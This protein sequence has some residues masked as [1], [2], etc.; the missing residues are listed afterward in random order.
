M[1]QIILLVSLVFVFLSCGG[2]KVSTD[3]D[4]STNF[5]K[6]QTYTFYKNMHTGLDEL[7][8]KRLLNSIRNELNAKG[9]TESTSK[10][11]FHVNVKT[12]KRNKPSRTHVRL[13]IGGGSHHV[14]GNVSVGIPVGQDKLDVK[15]EYDLVDDKGAG[16]FWQGVGQTTI[17]RNQTSANREKSINEMTAKVF[18]TLPS[19]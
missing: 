11:D 9:Y 17:N 4:E 13:G 12:T 19:R 2:S 16:L 7:D 18:E 15:L 5:S 8:N 1:K 10:P 6:Y 3:Y 14:G